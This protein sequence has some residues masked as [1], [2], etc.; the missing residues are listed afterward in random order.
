MTRQ[1]R[2]AAERQ[3]RQLARQGFTAELSETSP[4]QISPAFSP[5]S[6]SPS[7]I[8]ANRANSALS[9][10]PKTAV[11]KAASSQN[12][13][14]HGLYSKSLFIPG[15]D[16]AEFENM[17]AALVAEHQPGTETEA[18]FVNQMAEQM[19]RLRRARAFEAQV[20][21]SPEFNMSHM[22]A[23]LRFTASAE[24]GFHKAFKLLRELQAE[25]GFVPQTPQAAAASMPQN[26]PMSTLPDE[27]ELPHSAS[28]PHSQAVQII[29]EPMVGFDPATQS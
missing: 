11:G 27:S 15:E 9:T 22:N 5:A 14:Q 21:S 23:A 26:A 18:F 4:E 24:R 25:R 20:L 7:K 17:R 2:R 1:Q 3:A 8:A 6:V 12:A 10:G 16:P 28:M 13:R 29:N 19:W